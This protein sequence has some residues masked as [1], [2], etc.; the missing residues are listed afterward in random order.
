MGLVWVGANMGFVASTGVGAGEHGV[1]R[2][3]VSTTQ[4]PLKGACI[5]QL[6]LP[7]NWR[8]EVLTGKQTGM[9]SQGG[10]GVELVWARGD[11]DCPVGPGCLGVCVACAA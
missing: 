6:C 7:G 8:K 9:G 10:G 4:A 11:G 1:R 3:Q 2:N 5:A